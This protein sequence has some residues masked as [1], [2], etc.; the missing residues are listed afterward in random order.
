K[1]D[2]RTA[3]EMRPRDLSVS[4]F[5]VLNHAGAHEGRTQQEL[6]DALFVTKG[7]I[8]QLLDGMEAD[9]LL[10]RRRRGRTNLIY[11]TDEGRSLRQE[12]LH[13]HERRITTDMS[14]LSQDEQRTLLSLLRKLDKSLD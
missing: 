7:N 6:A 8:C 1:M 5:D 9:K 10:Y 14:A 12:A 2:R 4:R 3:E 13:E 11:L